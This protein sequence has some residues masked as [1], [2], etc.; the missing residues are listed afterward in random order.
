MTRDDAL[1]VNGLDDL[2]GKRVAA[3]IDSESH[4]IL[5]RCI[6][7]VE[8][9]PTPN[10]ADALRQIS[11]GKLDALLVPLDVGTYYLRQTGITDVHVA[12]TTPYVT[13]VR[14]GVR[15][16]WPE[17]V[18]ILDKAL[19]ALPHEDA[20]LFQN[21]WANQ[22][23]EKEV[24]WGTF[25]LLFSI[26]ALA[27][28]AIVAVNLRANRRLRREMREREQAQ[29]NLSTLLENIPAAV[30]M[31]DANQRYIMVNAAYGTFFQADTRAIVGKT[32]SEALPYL[33]CR[34]VLKGAEQALASGLTTSLEHSAVW[35]DGKTVHYST[36]QVPLRDSRGD[37]YAIVSLTT[38]ITDSKL[39]Q[40]E[41]IR[42]K[43]AAEAASQT[44]SDF[45]ANMSHEI[46]TPM[47]AIIGMSHLAL[48][49]ELT[50]R[51]KNYLTQIDASARALL[52]IINDILDFSKIE[53]GRMEMERT[54]FQLEPV[55]Q[56]VASLVTLNADQKGLELLFR[57]APDVPP[58]LIGD[59]L[60]LSQVLLNFTTNAVKFTEKGEVV[61]AAELA[62]R[63][64]RRALL[65]FSVRDTGVGIAQDRLNAVFD[66]FTQADASTTRRFG[67]TGLGLAISKRLV[68]MMGGEIQVESVPGRGSTFSF[69]AAFDI[70]EETDVPPR[71]ATE[72]L[73]GMRVLVVDDNATSR[74]LL[75][76]TLAAM[77]F[78]VAL[79]Q[80][81]AEALRRVAEAC[82]TGNPYRIILLDWKMPGMD[83]TETARRIREVMT[84]EQAATIIM[85]TAYEREE[86][87]DQI[88]EVGIREVLTKPV[89]PSAL[90]DAIAGALDFSAKN[91]T[92]EPSPRQQHQLRGVRVLLAEDNIINQQ[93]AREILLLFGV[94]VDM[95]DDGEEAVRKVRENV[96]DAVLM[97][98]QMP[99][100]DGLEAARRI[101][102]EIP[103]ARLP[104]VAMTAHAMSGDREKSLAA[105]MQDHVTKPIN[106]DALYATLARW[107]H[108]APRTSPADE[109]D[110]AAR[111]EAMTPNL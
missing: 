98:I 95:A 12:A 75:K 97:D 83:G 81:G 9:V 61:I 55:L 65:R 67:G 74:L 58:C 108:S 96:Y 37:N 4:Q 5:R 93:V 84:P 52:G 42:A 69:T 109:A 28:S 47:N 66:A 43:D 17:L 100:M 50:P 35:P 86:I 56:N 89:S 19:D 24:D 64:E 72:D 92:I 45:L 77:A 36:T 63:E 32:L 91:D 88:R 90:F 41:L 1:F 48:R 105:G 54:P 57:L 6:P 87:L 34:K 13:E 53:A 7:K 68:E 102:R 33:N 82:R 80:D 11:K 15:K 29:H 22:T 76:E 49:T 20:R 18:A 3:R 27:M 106:P 30:A 99:R 21:R 26:A 25:W 59:P 94:S 2:A 16:D 73:H 70:S 40:Q 110:D 111:T 46:R 44:K 62:A 85:V 78:A 101:R 71:S 31:R 39:L 23:A 104:I 10:A 51:Q 14:I 103:P 60:R 38:D 8:A 107:V 79:A